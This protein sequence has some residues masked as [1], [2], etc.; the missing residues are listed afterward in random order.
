MAVLAFHLVLAQAQHLLI[1]PPTFV[2]L[3]THLALH[4][5]SLK[6]I[7][8]VVLLVY[9]F[10]QIFVIPTVQ[11]VTTRTQETGSARFVT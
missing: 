5:H 2:R 9:T 10:Y 3:A 6:I 8:P 7:V 1:Q 4:A 11:P